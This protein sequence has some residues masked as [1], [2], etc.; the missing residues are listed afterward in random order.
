MF[1]ALIATTSTANASP[2]LGSKPHTTEDYVAVNNFNSQDVVN[3]FDR[4]K[5]PFE[6][7]VC[8]QCQAWID[9]IF[10]LVYL[11]LLTGNSSL[12]HNLAWKAALDS[13][14]QPSNS[15]ARMSSTVLMKGTPNNQ[16]VLQRNVA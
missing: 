6:Q 11:Q 10:F 13:F 14:H 9:G 1:P 15:N 8:I 2:E 4:S 5:H 3:H 12:E 16:E 7:R